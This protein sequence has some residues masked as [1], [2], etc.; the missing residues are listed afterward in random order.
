[1]GVEALG[2]GDADLMMM[3]GSFLG[4]QPLIVAFFVSVVPG[5]AF[6]IVYLVYRWLL[7][8]GRR[9]LKVKI[10][11]KEQHP[12]VQLAGQAVPLEEFGAACARLVTEAGKRRVLL[13]AAD[14][15]ALLGRTLANIGDVARQA[16]IRR[17][18]EVM[19]LERP[20][21]ANT[22]PIK[23]ELIPRETAVGVCVDGQEVSWEQMPVV[24]RERKKER[25]RSELQIDSHRLA[26]WLERTLGNVRL[27]V[28]AAGIQK[29]YRRDNAIPFGPAL[30]VGLLVSLLAWPWFVARGNLVFLLF[31]S[32]LIWIFAGACAVL[33]FLSSY[34]IRVMRVMRS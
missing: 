15:E 23:L 11:W 27:A 7:G 3:A 24:L 21:R 19:P 9:T 6:A 4:W 12:L 13:D 14:F 8:H 30:A 31:N 33:M 10:G 32:T 22:Q 28:R 16:G 18:R 17:L 1:L 25:P 2:L 29:I 26:K 5:L 34:A 20:R